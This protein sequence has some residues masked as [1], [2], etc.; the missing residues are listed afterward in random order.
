MHSGEQN[1]FTQ[2]QPTAQGLR[3]SRSFGRSRGGIL[4]D[5]RWPGRGA[6]IGACSAGPIQP[7]PPV[8][9][10]RLL[11]AAVPP[12]L[13][14][15]VRDALAAEP[16]VEVMPAGPADLDLLA[17]R[18]DRTPADVV[19]AES[20]GAALTDGHTELMYRHPRLTL[21]LV[22]PDGG[23]AATYRLTPERRVLEG[24]TPRG[25]VQAVLAATASASAGEG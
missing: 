11:L 3:G 4:A 5:G 22:A 12:L 15:I 19:L 17:E 21:L 6:S 13:A 20:A 14:D 10:T 18:L 23:T 16:G 7:L 24:P 8:P 25:L 1:G 9:R 2:R